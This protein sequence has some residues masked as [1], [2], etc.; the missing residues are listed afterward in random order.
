VSGAGTQGVV[1]TQV[2]PDGA[3]AAQGFKT[4]DVILDIGGES[5]NAPADVRRA[6]QDAKA[7]GKHTVLMRVKSEQGTH[8]V[9]VPLGNA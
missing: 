1:V 9:A 3:A 6:I 8:F 7:G 4:G 5:V 2:D